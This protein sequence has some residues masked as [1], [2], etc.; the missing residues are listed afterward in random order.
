MMR[1]DRFTAQAQD[2]ASRA[3]EVLQRYGHNQ[4]DTE[5]ILLAL[6]E[7]PESVIP[8]ILEQLGA[9]PSIINKRLNDVLRASPKG[10]VYGGGTGQVFITPRVKRIIDLANEEANR[11]GD[12]YIA[13]AHIFLAILSERNTAV[14][15]ILA[16]AGVSKEGV[17]ALVQGGSDPPDEKPLTIP[18]VRM[19]LE[20][21]LDKLLS[22]IDQLSPEDARQVYDRLRKRFDS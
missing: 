7:Q 11:L 16:E 3:Y 22:A 8:P 12:D 17:S 19:W 21:P 5:H 13:P 18:F 1:F 20:L 6:L 9:D 14:S 2:A 15:R 10:V 4:V